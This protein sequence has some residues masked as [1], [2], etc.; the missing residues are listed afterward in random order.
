[1]NLKHFYDELKQTCLQKNLNF[2]IIG[3]TGKKKNVPMYAITL[4]SNKKLNTLC[5]CA[6]IHGDEIAPIFAVLEFLKE[7]DLRKLKINLI[8][9][10]LANPT[11][12]ETK[13]R[14]NYLG[15]DINRHFS[16]KKLQN[17]NKIIYT[18][19]KKFKIH[20][21]CSLHEDEDEQEFYLY[22]FEKKK[23]KIYREIVSL[24]KKYCK[25]K[26]GEVEGLPNHVCIDGLI[27]NVEQ[28][29][30][31]EWRLFHEGTPF[32]LCTETPMKKKLK[33]RIQLNKEIMNKLV[34]FVSEK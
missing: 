31:L 15:V 9:F 22:N 13:K 12:F 2:K 8:I 1:M 6:G 3:K 5:I 24:A 32:A 7:I 17:E 30:S 19:L 27:I 34:E 18:C 29:G 25:I 20:C 11:S 21:I 16:D 23:E 4:K 14:E 26:E 10:P 33:E 28:D